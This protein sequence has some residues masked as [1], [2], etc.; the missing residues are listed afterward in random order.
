LSCSLI[1]S[2]LIATTASS[3]AA[4]RIS[5]WRGLRKGGGG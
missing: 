5:K 2:G 3:T 1:I 4:I